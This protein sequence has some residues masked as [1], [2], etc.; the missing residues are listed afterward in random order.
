MSASK[1]RV[2]KVRKASSMGWIPD[3]PDVRD[4]SYG[5]HLLRSER[6]SVEEMPIRG[7]LR[8][9]MSPVEDQ[10]DLGSCTANGIVALLEFL[11]KKAGDQTPT[12]LS[13]L[14][15]YYEE[16]VLINSVKQDSGA[17]I[18]DG[19][20]VAAKLGVPAE[21]YWPYKIQKYAVKPPPT[22]Y[23]KAPLHGALDYFRLSTHEDKVACLAAGYP[24]TFGFTVYENFW[25]V[26]Q[27]NPVAPMPEGNVEGGHCVVA[28]GWDDERKLYECR[29][30][31]GQTFA[32]EGYYWM[33]YGY[34]DDDNLADD[35]WTIR[36][37]GKVA[38]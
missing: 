38:A 33:P 26:N 19:I 22:A 11:E 20:K 28:V 17:Y 8:N 16:R 34:V 3:L 31:W 2:A 25:G 10:G 4:F 27:K 13:R 6:A 9:L 32:D 37:Q 24:F 18:R 21:S 12:N 30:S 35:F 36:K 5:E 14:F 7:S 15:L 1:S 29:N 23:K